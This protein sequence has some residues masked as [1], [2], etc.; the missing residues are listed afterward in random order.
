[1]ERDELAATGPETVARIVAR[2]VAA[3]RPPR[4]VTAGSL[5]E[6]SS[7][8][9]RRLLPARAFERIAARALLGA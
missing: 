4:R 3:D 6:R 8:L 1:M 5:S 2:V 9:L 7:V